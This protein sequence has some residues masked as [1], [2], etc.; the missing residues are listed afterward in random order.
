M[1]LCTFIAGRVS[2]VLG[3]VQA[4]LLRVG[5]SQQQKPPTAIRHP[6][7]GATLRSNQP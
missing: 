7:L 1:A 5:I 3:R 6:T 4:R 2:R